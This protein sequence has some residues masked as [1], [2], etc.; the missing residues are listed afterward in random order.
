MTHRKSKN[1]LQKICLWL[2]GCATLLLIAATPSV[3]AADKS[4]AVVAKAGNAALANSRIQQTTYMPAKSP[5]PP[6]VANDLGHF[7]LIDKTKYTSVSKG[8]F[9]TDPVAS[10]SDRALGAFYASVLAE[11]DSDC[12][13]IGTATLAGRNTLVF[14]HGSNKKPDDALFKLW[15]DS[16]TGLPLRVDFDEAEVVSVSTKGKDGLPVFSA[17]KTDKRQ[18]NSVA[19]LFG[20]AVKAPVFGGTKKLLGTPATVDM[21]A[22]AAMLALLN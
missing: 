14:E 15:I 11:M 17:K 5:R 10:D 6:P 19:F 20:D 22:T 9:F 2:Y 18:V 12:R 16:A 7:I 1:P 3:Y 8:L 21:Q 4:C 13:T